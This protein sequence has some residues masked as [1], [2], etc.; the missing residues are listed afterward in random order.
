MPGPP[1]GGN[2]EMLTGHLLYKKQPTVPIPYTAWS[3]AM[4]AHLIHSPIH[5]IRGQVQK[6]KAAVYKALRA[7]Y[8]VYR[9]TLKRRLC[10]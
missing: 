9:L 8:K 2:R 6:L 10:T 4:C 5:T 1:A 3:A 7:D